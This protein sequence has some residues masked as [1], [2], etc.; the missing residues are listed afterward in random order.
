VFNKIDR[1]D[2][3]IGIQLL[4]NGRREDVVYVSA[5]TGEGLDRLDESVSRKLDQQSSLVDLHFP[6]GEGRLN[7]LV[8]RMGR[9]LEDEMSVNLQD[10]RLRI[11]L[12]DA[13]LG[14]LRRTGGPALRI[15]IVE[16]A[17]SSV[18]EPTST[19]PP[20]DDGETAPGRFAAEA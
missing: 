14:N 13:A 8:H 12:T 20:R 6:I 19:D 15:E 4:R 10:R 11:R 2:D 5:M 3:R 16:A 1:V 17:S 9:P 7:A 18:P